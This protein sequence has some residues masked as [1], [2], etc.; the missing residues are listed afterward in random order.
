MTTLT[1]QQARALG[2][3]PL[4]TPFR[5]PAEEDFLQS[6]FANTLK[7]NPEA[8]IVKD[9]WK[10]VEIAYVVVKPKRAKVIRNDNP[11]AM[12]GNYP[13]VRQIVGKAI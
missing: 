5:L 11:K 2:M 4:S 9:R 3:R 8:R 13:T 12:R 6:W 7:H 1:K 10:K